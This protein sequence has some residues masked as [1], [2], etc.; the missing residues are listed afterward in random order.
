MEPASHEET[1]RGGISE[2]IE[3]VILS[4]QQIQRRVAELGQQIAEDYRGRDLLVVGVLCGSFPFIADLVRTMNLPLAIDF[5]AVS[6]YGN[7]TSSSGVV[8]ILKDLNSSIAGRHV[9][10]VEDIVDSGQTLRYLVDNL[11]TRRPASLEICTLLDK[12]EARTVDINTLYVG[13]DCPNEFVVGY[14]LDYAGSYRNLPYIG[15][16]K[17]AIYQ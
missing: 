6:S 2:D 11:Q 1:W 9:L 12:Q 3:R 13:F 17:P 8:R 16:L 4:A 14:G 15:V 7:R 5:M 10:L